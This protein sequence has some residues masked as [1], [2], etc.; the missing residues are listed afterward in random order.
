MREADATSGY[1]G[2]A[3]SDAFLNRYSTAS[4]AEDKAE[5]WAALMTDMQLVDTLPVL[6]K[7]RDMLKARATKL[8]GAMGSDRFWRAV[9]EAQAARRGAEDEW[10]EYA[11]DAGRPWWFNRVTHEKQ[12]ALT[13]VRSVHRPAA[14]MRS[15]RARA[16]VRLTPRADARTTRRWTRP[17]TDAASVQAKAQQASKLRARPSGVDL[18]LSRA[19]EVAVQHDAAKLGDAKSSDGNS[20][21]STRKRP[22][23]LLACFPCFSCFGTHDVVPASEAE[24]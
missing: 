12:C 17:T 24:L 3:G 13:R 18:E 7:K 6:A 5:I 15:P 16:C 2:S 22:R 19:P 14:P 8:L 1:L 10:E 11:T 21:P 4:A 9:R 20:E 23:L